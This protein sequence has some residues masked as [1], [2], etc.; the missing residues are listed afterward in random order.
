MS[1]EEGCIVVNYS[2][3][4]YFHSPFPMFK[5]L[6]RYDVSDGWG[7]VSLNMIEYTCSGRLQKD[8]FMN[9]MP[10]VILMCLV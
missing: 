2:D 10:F 5:S 7:I 3:Q 1:V 6:I 8:D 4:Q 9:S